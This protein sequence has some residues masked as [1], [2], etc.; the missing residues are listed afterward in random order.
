MPVSDLGAPICFFTEGLHLVAS[1]VVTKIFIRA[2]VCNGGILLMNS[3]LTEEFVTA[4]QTS[5]GGEKITE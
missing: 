1:R 4:Q 3:H 2:G 5:F